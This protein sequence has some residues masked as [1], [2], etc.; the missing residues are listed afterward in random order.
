MARQIFAQRR[1]FCFIGGLHS[2]LF[3]DHDSNYFDKL[4]EEVKPVPR[5]G[6][7]RIRA[8]FGTR[9]SHCDM[10]NLLNYLV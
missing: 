9:Y 1:Y 6:F 4:E 10:L 8:L 2:A 7:D 3:G 5:N